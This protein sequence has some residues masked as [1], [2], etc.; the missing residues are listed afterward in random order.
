M[1]ETSSFFSNYKAQPRGRRLDRFACPQTIIELLEK[2][3]EKINSK[4][5]S[6]ISLDN[7]KNNNY[8]VLVHL[9]QRGANYLRSGSKSK[10]SGKNEKIP[11]YVLLQI[12][13]LMTEILVKESQGRIS[14]RTFTDNY[15]RIL[16]CPNDI[17]KWLETG[18]LTLFEA[19][20]LKRLSAENL[21]VSLEQAAI[22]RENLFAQC[23]KE[24]WIIQR[25]RYEIDIKLGK[26]TQVENL[27]PSNKTTPPLFQETSLLL[28]REV[29]I[30][31]TSFF[32]EQLYSMIEMIN[33]IN[34]DELE[35]SEQEALFTSID[36]VVLQLQKITKRK[37]TKQTKVETPNLGFL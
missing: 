17:K 33:S 5:A 31:P 35:K 13:D 36:N 4:L 15:L 21:S 28:D 1:K 2:L 30:S 37:T 6:Y 29:S 25:L 16:S 8:E 22:I 27:A 18:E 24:K 20:Q 19:L 32:N 23:R 12:V 9:L 7:I 14:F 11:D 10:Q 34:F 26:A 3:I